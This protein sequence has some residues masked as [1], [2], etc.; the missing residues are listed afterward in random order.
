MRDDEDLLHL[1]LHVAVRDA[2]PPEVTPHEGR[3]FV[4][5]CTKRAV[6]VHGDGAGLRGS[7]ASES[8]L[9]PLFGGAGASSRMSAASIIDRLS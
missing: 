1:V 8:V 5:E 3:V 6:A 4:V 7:E 2:E 9:T